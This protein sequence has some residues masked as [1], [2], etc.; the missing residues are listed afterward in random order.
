MMFAASANDLVMRLASL[1]VFLPVLL[2]AQD[3]REI[4]RRATELDRTNAIAARNYT[5]L[6]RQEKRETDSAGKVK[7]V[8][9]ETWDVTLLE[10]SP[11]RRLVARNDPPLSAKEQSKEE[12]KRRA[13][14]EQRRKETPEQ[15]QNRIAEWDHHQQQR[16]E[17]MKELPEAFSFTLVKEEAIN[18]SEERRV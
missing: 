16:R 6:Q 10:G 3:A 17:P 18:R 11:Y 13:S 4:V 9:S 8:E 1:L 12:E 15:R 2:A 5:F 14:N 7:N